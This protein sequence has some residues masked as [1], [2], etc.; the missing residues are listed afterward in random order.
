MLY[1]QLFFPN[2]LCIAPFVIII[3][4]PYVNKILFCNVLKGAN[5]YLFYVLL[6]HMYSTVTTKHFILK[7]IS[8]PAIIWH[9]IVHL[10]TPPFVVMTDWILFGI[11]KCMPSRSSEFKVQK[12][13][14]NF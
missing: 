6:M 9:V 7:L 8:F 3:Y 5:H 2:F 14:S 12:F 10:V 1:I 4:I 13:D 11:A